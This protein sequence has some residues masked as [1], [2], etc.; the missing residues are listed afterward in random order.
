MVAIPFVYFT[1][2]FL[3]QLKKN[4]WRIDIASYILCIYAI[5]GFFTILIDVFNLRSPDTLSYT[6]SPIACI[7]YCGLITLC[8]WPFMSY[9]N[10]LF[11]GIKPTRKT[12]W[13]KYTAWIFALYFLFNLYMSWDSLS[14]VLSTDLGQVRNAHYKGMGEESW[15]AGLSSIA[16]LPFI[17]LN[18]IGGCPWIFIFLAFYSLIIQKLPLKYFILLLLASFNGVLGNILIAGRSAIAYWII[19]FV[20]C[21]LIYLHY[22]NKKLKRIIKSSFLILIILG[23]IFLSAVT[24]SRFG[25]RNEVQVSGTQGGLISY[26]GQSYINFCYFFDTFTCPLPSLQLI[27]PFTSKLLLGDNFDGTMVL[28][29]LLSFKTAKEIGVF[30]TFLGH[31]LVTSNKL[32]MIIYALILFFC[33]Y[34]ITK[35]SQKNL[36]NVSTCYF[37]YLYSSVIFLGIFTHYYAFMSI[38]FPVF[39]W[40]IILILQKNSNK[41]P[42]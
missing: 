41:P 26:F 14:Y 21:Y 15:M 31:I 12:K 36:L 17:L 10:L 27:F 19:S 7:S 20:G 13:L 23:I 32:V 30:Y 28:Q 3:Y 33:S 24:V 42:L 22:G 6:I 5:S 18:L 38:T 8:I 25:E 11:A 2:L 35:K 37:Y 1:L 40:G 34:Y 16:K 9:S 4:H 29:G 39:F